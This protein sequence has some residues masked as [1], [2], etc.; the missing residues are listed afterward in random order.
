MFMC[1]GACSVFILPV[2]AQ[3]VRDDDQNFTC[4]E[5]FRK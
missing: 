2:I 5:G 1:G 3:L 4:N